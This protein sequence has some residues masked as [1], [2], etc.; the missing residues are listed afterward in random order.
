METMFSTFDMSPRPVRIPAVSGIEYIRNPGSE[1]WISPELH[2]FLDGVVQRHESSPSE[3]GCLLSHFK[4]ILYGY[5]SGVSSLLVLED[6][7]DFSCVG[8]WNS[9]LSSLILKLDSDWNFVQLY[10]DY[11]GVFTPEYPITRIDDHIKC[12]GTVAYL[13]SA[14]CME[15]LYHMFF[16]NF[17]LTTSLYYVLQEMGLTFVSDAAIYNI[18]RP[19]NVYI[20]KLERFATN[21]FSP[22]LDSTIHTDHTPNHNEIT[23][24]IWTKYLNS[25]QTV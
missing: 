9:S 1:S 24:D 7:V 25:T 6:D 13:T 10:F 12:S 3:I 15:A 21:N 20:E 23:Y 14:R 19:K 8:L 17:V 16:N 18:L 11:R 2:P 4:A 22:E 5:R